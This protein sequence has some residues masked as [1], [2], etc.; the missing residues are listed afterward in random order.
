MLGFFLPDTVNFRILGIV[1]QHHLMPAIELN[2]NT[3][4]EKKLNK[5][6]VLL[7]IWITFCSNSECHCFDFLNYL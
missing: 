5:H 6:Y 2:I 7:F 4:E 3:I 1:S